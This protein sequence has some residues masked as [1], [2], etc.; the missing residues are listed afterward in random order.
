MNLPNKLTI[1]RLLLCV[2][3]VVFWSIEG[4]FRGATLLII[5][6]AASL[7]D[8]L[9][10][11]IARKYNLITDFGK[12]FDPLAD[13]ILISIAF[14]GLMLQQLVPFWIVVC[15]I[16][17]E[18]LIT[19]LRTLAASKGIVLSAE[20]MGKNKTISQMITA[21]VGLL[22]LAWQDARFALCI[23]DDMK[24]YLLLPLVALTLV[25]T[26]YSGLMYY[27]KNRKLLFEIT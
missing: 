17:R 7:T 15:I 2:L 26:V 10:G 20:Q 19:G 13:K 16:A 25:F 18:F 11:N 9:D 24:L 8:W 27:I 6:G 14:I 3:F 1:A 12:L 21:L 4:H 22:I 5:F 23:L